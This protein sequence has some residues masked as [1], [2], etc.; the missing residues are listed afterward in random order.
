MLKEDTGYS[1]SDPYSALKL[2]VLHDFGQLKLFHRCVE[3]KRQDGMGW[4]EGE[5]KV[6]V[7][8]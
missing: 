3:K 2:T 4:V 8:P 1:G 5:E 6:P 7:L